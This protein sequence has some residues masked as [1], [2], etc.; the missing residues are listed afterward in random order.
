MIISGEWFVCANLL[1]DVSCLHA[2]ARMSGK[3][4]RAGRLILSSALGTLCAMAALICWGCYAAAYAALP[5]AAMMAHLNDVYEANAISKSDLSVLVRLLCPFAP[6]LAEEMWEELGG[7]GFCSLAEWPSYDESK[8]V[9]ETVT[10][11][12]QISGK[13]RATVELPLNCPNDVA[14]ATAKADPKIASM[15]EGK[16]IIKEICVPNKIVNI[17]AK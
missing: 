7:E 12:V 1:L 14:I 11:A 17:V 5:I 2:V 15:L 6:H 3:C 8:T 16:T 10:V 9:D 4:V 13:V